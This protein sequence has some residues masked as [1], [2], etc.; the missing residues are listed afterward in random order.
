MKNTVNLSKFNFKN[1]G[2]DYILV[3][4]FAVLIFKD[5]TFIVA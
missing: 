4:D 2:I 3:F 1:S 5:V